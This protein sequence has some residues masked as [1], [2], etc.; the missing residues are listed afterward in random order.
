MSYEALMRLEKSF[1]ACLILDNYHIPKVKAVCLPSNLYY[2]TH[3]L[4]YKTI[5]EQADTS[6]AKVDITTLNT[7]LPHLTDELLGIIH[8]EPTSE[9]AVYYAQQIRESYTMRMANTLGNELAS[10]KD[11]N[12][13]ARLRHQLEDITNKPLTSSDLGVLL[14]EFIADTQR[15]KDG[16]EITTGLGVLDHLTMGYMRSSQYVIVGDT[17]HGKTA[18]ALW[19]VMENLKRGVK[20]NYY[21]Y[22]MSARKLV[23]RLACV[24]GELPLK[25]L[26]Y[27]MDF[28]NEQERIISETRRIIKE[29]QKDDQLIVKGFVSL[30]EIEADMASSPTGLVVVDF[31]QNAIDYTD[32]GKYNSEEQQLRKYSLRMKHLADK[33]KCCNLLLSQFSKPAD[34]RTTTMRSM[35]D[36]KGASA[37]AQNADCV[38]LIEYLYK[39]KGGFEN[40]N[41]AVVQVAKNNIGATGEVNL[42]FRPE[43]Q[44]YCKM[45]ITG[46]D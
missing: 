3:K 6:G 16:F 5:I 7:K 24:C 20:V 38:M 30:E 18:L 34:K 23:A 43:Y 33:Y 28:P 10:A 35:H 14:E 44:S 36:I 32:F 9:N 40:E 42:Y 41:K 19:G 2:D 15:N 25:W 1:L 8:S 46:K 29:Y 31:V 22:D 27:P 11:K 4:I 26:L 39:T 45:E 37:I 12:E 13:V 17:S 21:T